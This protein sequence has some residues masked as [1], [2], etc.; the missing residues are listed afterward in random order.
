[1][2]GSNGGVALD[3]IL[4]RLGRVVV[5]FSGGA[6]SAFLAARATRLLGRDNVLCVTA[7]SASLAASEE[8]DCDA[9][10]REWFLDHLTPIPLQ[11]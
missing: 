3:E 4:T 10:A 7:V 9:L 6:D 5:A 11:P 8:R 2:N 1:M